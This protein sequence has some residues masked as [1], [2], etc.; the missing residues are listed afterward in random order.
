MADKSKLCSELKKLQDC[1]GAK[2][3]DTMEDMEK[4][5]FK[6][7][8]VI[9]SDECYTFFM[10][11][12]G[13]ELILCKQID[14]NKCSPRYKANLEQYSLKIE[15]FVGGNGSSPIAQEFIEIFDIFKVISISI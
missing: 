1:E 14:M 10:A 8:K 9:V 13:E 6:I 3:L 2:E 12:K 5:G 11:Y 15:R 7:D 4:V